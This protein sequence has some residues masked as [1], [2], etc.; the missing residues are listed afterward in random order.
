MESRSHPLYG[1]HAD[2]GHV[3]IGPRVLGAWDFHGAP[4][5]DVL[6]SRG[7]R[8]VI[9]EQGVKSFTPIRDAV[10]PQDIRKGE[11]NRM[12]VVA[13]GRRLFFTINGKVASEVIDNEAAQRLDRGVIALQ[14]HNG[15]RM[16][17]EFRNLRMKRLTPQ[18]HV[19]ANSDK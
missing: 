13:R 14:L 4:R 9:D 3:G 8:V 17:V 1:Y 18:R 7:K 2:L 10:T 19:T 6:V 5:G 15:D 12:H 16:T 11:C